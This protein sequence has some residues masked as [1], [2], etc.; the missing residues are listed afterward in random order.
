MAFTVI[1]KK[2]FEN[3]VKNLLE[4]LVANWQDKVAVDFLLILYNTITVISNNP[5]VGSKIKNSNNIR[6][7]LV[8]KQVILPGRKK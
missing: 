2:R 5:A 6:S 7:L 8:T 1:T 4:Y 3:K